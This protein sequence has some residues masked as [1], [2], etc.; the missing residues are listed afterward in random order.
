MKQECFKGEIICVL[1]VENLSQ[2]RSMVE[3]LSSQGYSI[4]EI[5]LRSSDAIVILESLL[6]KYPNL[7]IGA[8]TVLSVDHLSQ[9][10][11]IGAKFAFS[12]GMDLELVKLSKGQ[13]FLYVPGVAT[14][15]EIQACLLNGV[16]LMKLFPCKA[17]GGINYM[18]AISAPF[19]DAL[20]IPTGGIDENNCEQY[21]EL[22]S[23]FAVGGSW[24]SKGI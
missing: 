18:Q 19:P 7:N 1:S 14:P 5:T 3:L 8:G 2:A 9:V 11:D 22:D 21:L 20:F 23:V 12:P 4:F 13:D 6:H 24:M 17:L 10:I 15:T 16:K